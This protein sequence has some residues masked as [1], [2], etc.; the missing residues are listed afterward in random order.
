VALD[1]P[2]VPLETVVVSATR[3]EARAFD[4][5]AA[6]SSVDAD[7][8]RDAGPQVNLSEPLA[9]V[10]GITVLN[11]QNYAQDLQLSIRGFGARSTFGIR[12][13]RLFVDGIPA[14][15][16]D[17]Q[18]QA[19]N[20]N[21]PTTARIEVLRG[22]LAILYGNAAG[23]VV[24]VFTEAGAAQPTV[25]ASGAFADY[26]TLR[27]GAG[28]AATSGE[29]RF[30]GDVSHFE[31]D[32][33][34][35]HSRAERDVANAKWTWQWSGATR[36]DAVV[37]VLDQP[38]ALDPLGLTR[39]QWQQDPR[40]APAIAFTQDASKTV[41]QQQAGTVLRHDWQGGT[42]LEA[43][44][45]GGS[46]ELDN[47]LSTPLANQLPPTSSGGIVSFDRV[48]YG[49][50]LQLSRGFALGRDASAR[51]VAAVEYDRMKDDRQ[52]YVNN[53]GER[54]ALRRDEDDIVHNTDALLQASVDMGAR[55]SAVA[56]VRA[57][58]VHFQTRDRYIAPGNPDD[59]GTLDYHSTNPVGGLTWHATPD[60]NVYANAGR[61]FETPTFTELA[62]RNEG[63]GL[64]TGL[65]ASRSDHLELGT[66]WR[67]AAAHSVEAA[68]FD[69]RTK[70]EIVVDT[71]VGGR[72]TFRNAGSTTRRGVEAMYQ[73]QWTP[74]L[75]SYVAFTA[76][77]ARFEN[78]NRLP[79]TPGRS[80]FGELAF[81]PREAW[82][83]AIEVMHLGRIFVND[84]NEDAAPSWTVV[85]LRAGGRFRWGSLELEPLLR[86]DNA[87]GRNYAGSVIVNEAQR[88]FFE[89]AP[90]RTWM[91]SVTARYR[92]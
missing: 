40:Q 49:G 5:P 62:Y 35:H 91:L 52:G 16:P 14:T 83:A 92:G 24:Q 48:Y 39:A 89:P 45:Y 30:I 25:N 65:E 59:S 23:G 86:L 58:R 68:L 81:R 56:G 20:V 66:K 27:Y 76:L 3:G 33:Y 2:P 43:R 19:S 80:A 85:N 7:A 67:A 55:W 8:I 1:S 82:H 84:A 87:T 21:L 51:I 70:D 75:R 74:W 18:G 88:R 42:T 50:G 46:R 38:L 73:A 17:G 10:P 28:F 31:T 79:G 29:H 22:P 4:V 72:S 54:G 6:I 90:G 61:G 26:G 77:D 41:R 36:I 9:R 71:N 13:V 64:N 69:I 44:A 34:R 12:G 60:W 11:R 57:S 53:A 63:S 47:K 32:G 15:M 37:N 78:G